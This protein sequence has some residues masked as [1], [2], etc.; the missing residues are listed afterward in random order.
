MLQLF[1]TITLNLWGTP[2]SNAVHLQK[3]PSQAKVL[4]EGRDLRE[5]QFYVPLSVSHSCVDRIAGLINRHLT[6]N[7]GLCFR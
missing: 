4:T 7:W 5:A 2:K 1:T 6:S 3:R